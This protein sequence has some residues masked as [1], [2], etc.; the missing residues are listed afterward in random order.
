MLLWISLA[1]ASG[2]QSTFDGGNDYI[3][4]GD[5]LDPGSRFTVEM[6]VNLD[7]TNTNGYDTFFEVVDESTAQN[8]RT[9]SEEIWSRTGTHG[10]RGL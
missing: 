10:A 6:W 3:D 2:N 9:E 8:T 5:S 7:S 1:L 4:L